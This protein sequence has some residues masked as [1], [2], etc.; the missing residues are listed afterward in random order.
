MLV[1][2]RVKWTVIAR[3]SA[4]RQFVLRAAQEPLID[5]AW[6]AHEREVARH[7]STRVC[8]MRH[9]VGAWR[10]RSASTKRREDSDCGIVC[11]HIVQV[12]EDTRG[13]WQHSDVLGELSR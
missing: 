11:I 13:V 5:A 7:E 1:E 9:G 6:A 4:R 12:A 2:F 8:N 3:Q 10:H